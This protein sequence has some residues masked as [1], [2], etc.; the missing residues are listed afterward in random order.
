MQVLK[1]RRHHQQNY[2]TWWS[3]VDYGAEA[4]VGSSLLLHIPAGA[5]GQQLPRGAAGTLSQPLH[6]RLVD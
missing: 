6:K 4:G 2:F 5:A 1:R 3:S